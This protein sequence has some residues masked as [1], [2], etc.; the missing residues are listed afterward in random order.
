LKGMLKLRDRGLI[1]GP[2]AQLVLPPNVPITITGPIAA[3]TI[4]LDVSQ[5]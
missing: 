2:A 5:R 4:K 3:P 1:V